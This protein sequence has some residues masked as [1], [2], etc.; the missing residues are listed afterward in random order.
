MTA[1]ALLT[2]LCVLVWI[3]S[4]ILSAIVYVLA[5]AGGHACPEVNVIPSSVS[6]VAMNTD[7]GDET[8]IPTPSTLRSR[9]TAR[10]VEHSWM[11]NG[12]FD[13]GAYREDILSKSQP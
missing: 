5:R 3:C 6:S 7:D 10:S 2:V 12:E 9:T 13:I 1:F 4:L 11:K 8:S